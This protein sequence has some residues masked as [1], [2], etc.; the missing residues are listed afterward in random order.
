ML[1]AEPDIVKLK[2][3]GGSTPLMY[4]VLYGEADDVRLLLEAGAEPNARNEV[5]ATAL[6]W[7]ADDLDKTRLLLRAGADPNARSDDGRTPLL[8]ATTWPQSTDVVKLLLDRGANPSAV[9]NSYRGPLTPLRLAAEAG[10]E[11]AVRLLLDRG[12]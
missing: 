9:V 12:A 6:M 7:A 10:H 11:A 8:V 1:R 2:G 4:A 3:P 5:G